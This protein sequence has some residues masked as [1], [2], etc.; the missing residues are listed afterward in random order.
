MAKWSALLLLFQSEAKLD[1]EVF[2]TR[3]HFPSW[4]KEGGVAMENFSSIAP[5][6]PPTPETVP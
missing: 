2:A 5:P 1:V 4:M 3:D 6:Y